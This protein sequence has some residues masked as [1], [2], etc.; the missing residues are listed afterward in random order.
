MEQLQRKVSVVA[1]IADY[2]TFIEIVHSGSISAAGRRLNASPANVSAVLARLEKQYDARLL[3]RTTRNQQL[4]Y[5]GEHFYQFCLLAADQEDELLNHLSKQQQLQGSITISCTCDFGRNVLVPL[6]DEFMALY[7]QL[8]IH[9]HLTD[10]ISDLVKDSIDVA[11]RFGALKDSNLVARRLADNHRVLVASPEYLAQHG[12]PQSVEELADHAC[13]LISREGETQAEWQF[14][15]ANQIYSVAVNA[16]FSSNNGE[17]VKHWALTSKG[18]AMKSI[19]DVKPALADGT[20][21]SVL[22]EFR[23]DDGAVYAVFPN[24]KFS[25][26]RITALIDFLKQALQQ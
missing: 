19:W 7:P 14:N 17:V 15:K 23:Q 22:D 10:K 4:T 26:Q 8:S 9:L 13:L 16:A 12:H 24:R 1:G 20:L 11:I 25:P 18:I 6:L 21:V 5:E 3:S 2:R